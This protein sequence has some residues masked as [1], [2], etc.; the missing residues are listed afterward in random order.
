MTL[1]ALFAFQAWNGRDR[2]TIGASVL[3]DYKLEKL[4]S[5]KGSADLVRYRGICY[6]G[7]ARSASRALVRTGVRGTLMSRPWETGGGFMLEPLERWRLSA[8]SLL[9]YLASSA[10]LTRKGCCDLWQC[11]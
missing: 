3:R 8:S 9:P 7:C 4:D 1:R 11:A 2:R 5:L 6:M 10:E